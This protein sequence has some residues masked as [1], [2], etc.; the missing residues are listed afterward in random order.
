MKLIILSLIL[1]VLF[2]SFQVC[3]GQKESKPIL[4]KELVEEYCNEIWKR[5]VDLFLNEASK[6]PDSKVYIL[7]NGKNSLEGKNLLYLEQSRN[8]IK[9]RGFDVNRVVT[10]RGENK[11]KMTL[12]LWIVPTDAVPPTVSKNFVKEKID[13][14]I[15]FDKSW[16]DWYQGVVLEWTIYSYSYVNEGCGV[17]LNMK[18]FAE[19]LNSQ[20]N[21]TGY[22]VVYTKFGKGKR[23]AKKV[24]DFALKELTRQYKVPK[25]R[26]KTI[27]GGNGN[28]PELELW[29][30][31]DGNNLSLPKP[32]KIIKN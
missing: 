20:S 7:F 2:T 25:S 32:D 14:T 10:V 29:F 9:F 16:A 27:Y 13:S 23:Q 28:E 12:Q 3:L 1:A 24:T 19:T 17:D 26:L 21:L 15:L 18:A 8:Y 22:L 31:P 5:D 6:Y 30:V 4:Y 11:D